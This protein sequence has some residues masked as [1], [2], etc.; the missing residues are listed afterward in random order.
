MEI[1]EEVEVPEDFFIEGKESI[2]DILTL[3]QIPMKQEYVAECSKYNLMLINEEVKRNCRILKISQN[4]YIQEI[5]TELIVKQP[6][7]FPHLLIIISEVCEYH[8]IPENEYKWRKRCSLFNEKINKLKEYL[9]K[10]SKNRPF[11]LQLTSKSENLTKIFYKSDDS[12]KFHSFF[13]NRRPKKIENFQNFFWFFMNGKIENFEGTMVD[14]LPNVK[15][16]ALIW[17]YLNTLTLPNDFF[18]RIIIKCAA[19]GT[20]DQ[21]LT[22]LGATF[23]NGIKSVNSSVMNNMIKMFEF[24]LSSEQSILLAAVENL[25]TE[26]IKYLSKDFAH[27]FQQLPYS[28]KIGILIAPY[29]SQKNIEFRENFP[30]IE[31]NLSIFDLV[32]DEHLSIQNFQNQERTINLGFK[33][34]VIYEKFK[35]ILFNKIKIKI[36]EMQSLY[37]STNKQLKSKF[38]PKIAEL[39]LKVA[40]YFTNVE[41]FEFL[42]DEVKNKY[43]HELV[44]K[45]LN[46]K[47]EYDNDS[48][49]LNGIICVINIFQILSMSKYCSIDKFQKLMKILGNFFSFSEIHDLMKQE[50]NIINECIWHNRKDSFNKKQFVAMWQKYE[51]YFESRNS[52]QIFRKFIMQEDSNQQNILHNAANYYNMLSIHETLWELLLKT[53]EDHREELWI[54]MNQTWGFCKANFVHD[55]VR[56]MNPNIIKFTLL[57]VKNNFG[58]DKFLELIEKSDGLGRNVLYYALQESSREHLDYVLNILH[59]LTSNMF[60]K[61]LFSKFDVESC[62]FLQLVAQNKPFSTYKIV[63][64]C[65]KKYFNSS[66]ILLFTKHQNKDGHN[67]LHLTVKS[68]TKELADFTWSEFKKTIFEDENICDKYSEEIK[69]CN[70]YFKNVLEMEVIDRQENDEI[71]NLNWMEEKAL[72]IFQLSPEQFNQIINQ[73]NF[74]QNSNNFKILASFGDLDVHKILWKFLLENF[75]NREELKK[76]VFDV[77]SCY[78]YIFQLM[79]NENPEVVKFTLEIIHRTFSESQ[80]QE[81]LSSKNTREQNLLQTAACSLKNVRLFKILF[82]IFQYYFEESQIEAFMGHTDVDGNC[83]LLCAASWSTKEIFETFWTEWKNSSKVSTNLISLLIKTRNNPAE[84]ILMLGLKSNDNE[85]FKSILTITKNIFETQNSLGTYKTF[86]MQKNRKQQNILHYAI[87]HSEKVEIHEMLWEFL[88][89]IFE[90]QQQQLWSLINYTLE[91]DRT[92]FIYNLMRNC[93]VDII[94]FTL[95]IIVDNFE[96]EKLLKSLEKRNRS[97]DNVLFYFVS[98]SS[99]EHFEYY[100]D[101][102]GKLLSH[103][104]MHRL[105]RCLNADNYNL[106]QSALKE[107]N[108]IKFHEVLWKTFQKYFDPQYIA[109][110]IKFKNGTH[111]SFIKLAFMHS[112]IDIIRLTFNNIKNI[113]GNNVI[114]DLLME[115]LNTRVDY[116]LPLINK[117]EKAVKLFLEELNSLETYDNIRDILATLNSKGQNFLQSAAFKKYSMKVHESLW[118]I[119]QEYYTSREIKDFIRY[120]DCN[121]FNLLHYTV[122][123]NTKEIV[124]FTWNQIKN[125][126]NEIEHAEL[127][128]TNDK[129]ER[130]LLK[131]ASCNHENKDVEDFIK[132]LLIE[133]EI[134]Q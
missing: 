131:I 38:I 18:N 68:N 62:N 100:V 53:F 1:D 113:C 57:I 109:G 70:K 106:L 47:L 129:R 25:N 78:N 67:L 97:G 49:V 8:S 71:L 72:S 74:F 104:D 52:S 64:K 29:G 7:S 103:E 121:G 108:S 41:V 75:K 5:F 112:T 31:E 37:S 42:T 6:S 90:N 26:V 50:K 32:C 16:F 35:K 76:V 44:K 127:L 89:N 107:S 30:Y 134:V 55:L 133:Y 116:E 99:I 93:K 132:N 117:S 88:L 59:E 63:W 126:M 73:G 66:E 130:N 118:H 119:L 40:E 33:E 21:L 3:N 84:N 128:G 51:I 110:V 54:F 15:D 102:L 101:E 12:D 4:S 79:S 105:L 11:I 28:H 125:F 20:K 22:V 122:N 13:S 94:G 27:V 56:N 83:L 124:E 17:N 43:G 65:F 111:H 14:I 39:L 87:E 81:I 10:F 123:Y 19:K 61:R 48:Y 96:N 91:K 86:V 120:F 58:N 92:D 60:I 82:N 77:N 69:L 115:H 98:K 2:F 85:K 95:K 24:D 9:S 46:Q 36:D 23:E 80:V 45:I 34:N 114:L